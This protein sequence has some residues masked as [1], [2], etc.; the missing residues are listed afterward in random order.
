LQGACVA[1]VSGALLAVADLKT[2]R[3]VFFSAAFLFKGFLFLR[4]LRVESGQFWNLGG[5]VR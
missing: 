5:P 4:F 2:R 1:I 3:R